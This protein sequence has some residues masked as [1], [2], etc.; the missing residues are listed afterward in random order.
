MLK[1]LVE[2]ASQSCF[3]IS[4]MREETNQIREQLQ[5]GIENAEIGEK[6]ARV[7]ELIQKLRAQTEDLEKFAYENGHGEMPL[8]EL[9]QRQKVV[10]DKL[11]EKIQLKIELEKLSETEFQQ[12]LDQGLEEVNSPKTYEVLSFFILDFEPYKRERPIGRSASNSNNRPRAFRLVP[13]TRVCGQ[14]KRRG[15][16]RPFGAKIH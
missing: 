11:K 4:G 10:F 12:N 6:K 3:D 8:F 14:R 13:A 7:V 16:T 15:E 2:F 1:E 5:S 9:K